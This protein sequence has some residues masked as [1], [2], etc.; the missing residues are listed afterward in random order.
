M[1]NSDWNHGN[2]YQ[3]V[4]QFMFNNAQAV[5]AKFLGGTKRNIN[6]NI[7]DINKVAQTADNRGKD[8]KIIELDFF[9]TRIREN[10]L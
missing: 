7:S 1:M 8:R 9:F 6:N 4:Q 5:A 2:Q 3:T 10:D